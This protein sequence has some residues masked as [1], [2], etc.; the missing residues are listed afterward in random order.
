MALLLV[1]IVVAGFL[2]QALLA[3]RRPWT[4]ASGGLFMLLLV[5]E[6]GDA[7]S[8]AGVGIFIGFF[9]LV[10]WIGARIAVRVYRARW[11]TPTVPEAHAIER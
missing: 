3:T 2:T 11:V 9:T 5:V 8:I 4:C 6:D 7:A 10:G 1:A